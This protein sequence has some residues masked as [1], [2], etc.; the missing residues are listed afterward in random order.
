MKLTIVTKGAF[1]ASATTTD[2]KT[3]YFTKTNSSWYDH[4][5]ASKKV[6]DNWE[7][8]DESIVMSTQGRPFVQ[9]L[10]AEKFVQALQIEKA[11]TAIE[12]MKAAEARAAAGA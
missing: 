11:F 9:R 5:V 4:S 8:P 1:N 2:G 6:G 10:N 7:V 3:V 12:I